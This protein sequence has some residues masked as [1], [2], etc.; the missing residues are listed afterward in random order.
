MQH[1]QRLKSK[2]IIPF[3]F[4]LTLAL[5]PVTQ[6]EDDIEAMSGMVNLMESFFE[7]MDSVYAMNADA[8][9]AALLQMHE[10]EEI[11]K[12]QGQ[13]KKAVAI[14]QEVLKRSNNPTMRNIAYHRM[15]DVLKESG[16]LSAAVDILN[17]ALDE[18]LKRTK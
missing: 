5:S 2:L 6:A 8:E 15:A 10:I 13:H 12:Q 7:L 4:L 17:K 1:Y 11:Y 14:Y 9:K 18:S 3:A 16:D